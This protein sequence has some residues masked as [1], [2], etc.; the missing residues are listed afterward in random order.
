MP[1]SP[2]VTQ[3]F[4]S[5]GHSKRNKEKVKRTDHR[6]PETV[7][8]QNDSFNFWL[9]LTAHASFDNVWLGLM[10]VCS[11][12]THSVRLG[13]MTVHV[14]LTVLGWVWWLFVH[15]WLTV[16]GWVWRLFVHVQLT[17]F[18]VHTDGVWLFYHV[19][20]TVWLCV[21]MLKWQAEWQN[22]RRRFTKQW[23]LQYSWAFNNVFNNVSHFTQTLTTIK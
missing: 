22:M 16:L 3:F 23:Q 9:C 12:L 1:A 13:L 18:G 10:T 8:H 6:K 17:V 2:T 19:E 21:I 20:M 11:C 4:V 7:Q 15:V 14:W 5:I